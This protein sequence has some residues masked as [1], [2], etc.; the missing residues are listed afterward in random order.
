MGEEAFDTLMGAADPAVVVV[1]TASEGVRAGCLV[2]YH[3]QSS[4]SPQQYCLWL[5]KAN[6]TYRVA[7]RADHFAVHFL[8]QQDLAL[9]ERFGARTGLETDKFAGLGVDIDEHGVPLIRQCP[10]RFLLERL[11]LLDDGGDHVCLTGRVRSAASE[12]GLAPLRLTD[13]VHLTPGRP[14]E[15]RSVR[16]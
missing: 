15:D 3:A 7:L 2:G 8:T 5:S 13:V 11:T 12:G 4:M 16:P 10:H 9:A 6:H 1:T 14:S